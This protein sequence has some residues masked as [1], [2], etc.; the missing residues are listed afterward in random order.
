MKLTPQHHKAIEALAMGENNKSVAE[1]LN[2]AP[3]TVSR[4]R[5]DFDFQAALNSVLAENRESTKD[6]LRHLSGVALETIEAIMTDS[7]APAKDRLT[8]ALK[9]LEFS[10]LSVGRV[11]STDAAILRKEKAQNDFMLNIGL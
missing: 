2:L 10:K 5:S 8:A 3:E 4:W 1:K 11:P 6:R 7:E 9:V